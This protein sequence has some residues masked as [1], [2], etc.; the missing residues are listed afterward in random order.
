M[1]AS[2]NLRYGKNCGPNCHLKV[3]VV[4]G[5]HS[6]ILENFSTIKGIVVSAVYTMSKTAQTR[7]VTLYLER[8]VSNSHHYGKNWMS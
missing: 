8:P 3:M 6:L 2:N 5:S 1:Y 7:I 4:C